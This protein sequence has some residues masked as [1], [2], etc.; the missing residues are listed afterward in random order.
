M[1]FSNG[2]GAMDSQSQDILSGL[3]G[4]SMGAATQPPTAREQLAQMGGGSKNGVA[5]TNA[6]EDLLGLF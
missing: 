4:L 6:N 5:A 3:A 1:G 2:N